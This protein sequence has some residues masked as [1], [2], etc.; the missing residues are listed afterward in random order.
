MLGEYRVTAY[1]GLEV[2][3]DP[4]L[5]GGGQAFGQEFVPIVSQLFGHAARVYEPCAGCGFIGF[6]L[7]AHGLCS[8]LVL[9]DVNPRSVEVMRQTVERN[10][11]AD[12]VDVFLSDGLSQIP[13]GVRFD[14]VVSNP[15][16][17]PSDNGSLIACDPG[18]AFHRAFYGGIAAYLAPGASLLF[19]ENSGGGEHTVFLPMLAAGGL[20]VIQS[21]RYAADVHPANYFL[22]SKPLASRLIPGRLAPAEE[23]TFE[24]TPAPARYELQFGQ[25]YRGI[26]VNRLGRPVELLLTGEEQGV[27]LPVGQDSVAVLPTFTLP[28]GEHRVRDGQ[29]G[30]V[31]MTILVREHGDDSR[32]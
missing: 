25:E 15:P 13:A 24:L 26:I 4:E 17:Y 11:L 21:L 18:W 27:C 32:A 20:S 22:W 12:R 31:V 5:D 10:N 8:H 2:L 19:Q 16:W 14:L 23:I 30:T 28:P 6:S 9:S 3:W 7:L 29:T 1:K